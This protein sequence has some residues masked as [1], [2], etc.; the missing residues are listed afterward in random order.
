MALRLLAFKQ[1]YKI[2]GLENVVAAANAARFAKK[3][4]YESVE[5]AENESKILCVYSFFFYFFVCNLNL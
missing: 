4:Q 3:R 5:P 2:L 1:I